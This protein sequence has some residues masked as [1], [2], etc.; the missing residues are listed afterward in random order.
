M[1]VPREAPGAWLELDIDREL[2]ATAFRVA[3][4]GSPPW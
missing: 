1:V 2:V 4:T 3:L